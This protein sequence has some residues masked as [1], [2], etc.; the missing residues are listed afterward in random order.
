MRFLL[1]ALLLVASCVTA[2]AQGCGSTNP[3]CIVPTAPA[4]TSDNRAAST[5]F[6]QSSASGSAVKGPASSVVG[7]VPQW[8]N[9]LGTLLSDPATI[10]SNAQDFYFGTGRPWCD[11]RAKGA[12]GDGATDD[13]AAFSACVTALAATGGILYV[14]PASA[15][16][17]L[18]SSGITITGS[19]SISMVCGGFGTE[20]QVGTADVT[21]VTLNNASH[22]IHDCLIQGSNNVNTTHDAIS[23]GSN[24]SEC[25]LDRVYAQYGRYVINV[26]AADVRM[27]HIHATLAYGGAVVYTTGSYS[28]NACK[29][30]TSFP[31]NT[32]SQGTTYA[33]WQANHSYTCGTPA[34]IVQTAG[35]QAGS[36]YNI[37]CTTS[38]TS[39]SSAPTLQPFTGTITDGTAAWKLVGQSTNAAA[40]ADTGS[41]TVVFSNRS[42]LSGSYTYGLYI[43]G[44]AQSVFITNS[45]IGG[46]YS[47]GIYQN[48]TVGGLQAIGNQITNCIGVLCQGVYLHAGSDDIVS[49]NL[50]FGNPIGAETDGGK[51]FSFTG[52]SI[53][54]SST[55]AIFIGGTAS[56][57]AVTGNILGTSASWGT[58]AIGVDIATSGTDYLTVVGNG[59]HGATTCVSNSSTGT[60]NLIETTPGIITTPV[61]FADSGIWN[62]TGI[63][64]TAINGS[65]VG[66]TTPSTGA[67]TTLSATSTVN[68]AGITALFASPPAIGGTVAAGGAFTTLSASST[69]SGTG[70]S[71][72]LASPPAIGG[73]AP[74]A[75][76]F[77]T[78]SATGVATLTGQTVHNVATTLA[79]ATA[80]TLDDVKVSAATTTITGNTGSPITAL[81]KTHL[82]QPTLTD[83]S[84]VT[85]TTA[86]TL[87]IDN[88]PAQAGSV[89]ITNAYALD[90]IAGSSL[91]GGKVFM[92]GLTAGSGTKA[93]CLNATANEIQT[94]T[95][96]TIC[97]IS[98][99]RYKNLISEI[100]PE[101]GL[102][103]LSL[104]GETYRYKPDA[105]QDDK[106]HV[107][108]IADDMA[109]LNPA[110]ANYSPHGV[111]NYM[112]RCFE[113]YQVAYDKKLWQIIGE[114]RNEIADL[115]RGR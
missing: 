71:T 47:A 104:R 91:F 97:G 95:S 64:T 112:D 50:I 2:A 9:T 67:F 83:S 32:P 59:C 5:A 107:S 102:G 3:N 29:L 109:A 75:G 4:G 51:N 36:T 24:C 103:V 54:G 53:F 14:P 99:L 56:I 105:D 8:N 110:C 13:S 92:S 17:Y 45:F 101:Q 49:N 6:V 19:V 55:A 38:G 108:L 40:Q 1:A 12:K 76:S 82:G 11:V 73:S 66:A 74:A 20:I 62:S 28:C 15:A 7:D 34:L 100:T 84:A 98:A 23:L 96:A 37:Q 61:T 79:S 86:A 106:V 10:S 57:V 33:A 68:G 46:A 39:G 18:V 22:E 78:L 111:E 93:L 69:V 58:N 114:L 81:S 26:A 87:A 21:A 35:S 42:D 89:T 85:V 72:Y 113:A 43:T 25:L 65:T 88:A 44:N 48:S 77:T 90:V 30:D 16:T 63:T 60:H 80:A 27:D 52:N 115:R 31:V 70:F 94:D 41:S